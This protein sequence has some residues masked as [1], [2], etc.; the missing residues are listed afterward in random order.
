MINLLPPERAQGIRYGR[1][2]GILLRWLA[3]IASAALGLIIVIA[4]GWLYINQQ[5]KNFQ[6]NIVDSQA[7][8]ASQNLPKIRKDAAEISGDVKVINQ[9]LGREI[10]FSGLLEA[11]GQV[12]PPGTVLNSLTLSSA[13]GA[14][15][16]SANAKDY[17]S[18][19]Q[20]AVNLSDPKNGLFSKVDIVSI[21]CTSGSST[22]NCNATLKALFSKTTQNKFLN[23]VKAGS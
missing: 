3:G 10:N 5:S 1:L 4:G 20:I 21:N 18:A 2:N 7:Q 11:I 13:N 23:V 14:V 17:S 12:M 19:T 6:S 15:D 16:L 8:L 22:Y 9:V